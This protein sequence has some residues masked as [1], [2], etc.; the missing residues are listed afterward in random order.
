M[1]DMKKLFGKRLKYIRENNGY[2]QEKFAEKIDINSR[3]LSSIE[4]GKSFVTSDTLA[5]ICT[6]LEINPKV[7]FDFDFPSKSSEDMKEELISLINKNEEHLTV[8]Y[9]IVKSYLQ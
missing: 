2:T 6:A 1:N 7:L 5:R 3:A 9:R 4:C 8:I